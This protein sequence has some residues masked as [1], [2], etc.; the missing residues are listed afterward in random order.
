MPPR[1][2]AL[3]RAVSKKGSLFKIKDIPSLFL[4]KI[5]EILPCSLDLSPSQQSSSSG[6][7]RP[8]MIESETPPPAVP[9]CEAG[10][11][12]VSSQRVSLSLAGPK[13]SRMSPQS[14]PRPAF[15]KGHQ[16]SP[17]PPGVRLEELK[18]LLRRASISEDPRPLMCTVIERI[19]SAE[20]GLHE[21]VRSLLTGLEVRKM[22]YLL[23]VPHIKC[24]LCR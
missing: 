3:Y 6:D 13:G 21:S 12:E 24:A 22:M 16:T 14:P 9:S 8:E 19:S 1:G 7:L 18:D 2:S 15:K 5:T 17:A 11:P 20:S 10:D 4:M 23:T